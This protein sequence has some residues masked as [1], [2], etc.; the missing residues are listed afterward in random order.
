M[1]NLTVA[2]PVDDGMGMTIFGKRQSSDRVLIADFMKDHEGKSIYI[3]SFSRR[4]FENYDSV[5]ITDDP[6]NDSCEGGVLFIEN[7]K[8]SIFIGDV[9]TLIIYRWNREYP[10][11]TKFDIDPEKE[12]FKLISATD[13]VGSSHKK[14]SKEIYIR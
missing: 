11:D 1:K 5:N 4:L 3:S 2:I 13:F 14:I 7:I 10:S 12:G 6:I 9:G 8:P